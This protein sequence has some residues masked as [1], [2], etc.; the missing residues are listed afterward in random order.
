M[1]SQENS[2]PSDPLEEHRFKPG[3]SGNPKGR[4]KGTSIQKAIRALLDDGV[5]G[6]DLQKA[7]ARVAVQRALTGDFKFYQMVLE[8]IDG[9]VIDKIESDNKLEIVVKYESDADSRDNASE[10]T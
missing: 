1:S 6:Q 5:K 7:L 8:R 3:Q 10:T 9:K 2:D 4:P